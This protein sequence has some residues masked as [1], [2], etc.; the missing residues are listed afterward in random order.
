MKCTFNFGVLD[1]SVYILYWILAHVINIYS[2]NV[3][4]LR[5]E[6][7]SFCPC[8]HLGLLKRSNAYYMKQ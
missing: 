5:E 3:F 7:E 1:F 4:K 6:K 2:E 8:A